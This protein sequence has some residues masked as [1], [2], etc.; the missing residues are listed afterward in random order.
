MNKQL[1]HDDVYELKTKTLQVLQQTAKQAT[2]VGGS[3]LN[4]APPGVPTNAV[5]YLAAIAKEIEDAL[6]KFQQPGG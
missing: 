1:A 3:L 4:A 6:A 5:K 2:D